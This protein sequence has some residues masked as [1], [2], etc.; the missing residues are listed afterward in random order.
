MWLLLLAA[1]C[2][3]LAGLSISP[4]LSLS[5]SLLGSHMAHEGPMPQ[6]L[7]L[8]FEIKYLEMWSNKLVK[9]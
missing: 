3:W 4:L 8:V 9:I 7:F 5:H 6:G 1:A 2:C